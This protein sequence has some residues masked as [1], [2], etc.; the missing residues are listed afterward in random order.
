MKGLMN[1]LVCLFVLMFVSTVSAQMT[2]GYTN[3]TFD[4]RDGIRFGSSLEQ[5][6][7]IK[8]SKEKLQLLQG[9]K[10]IGL[11]AA[12]GSKN[13]ENVNFFISE[14]AG[15]ASLY[16]QSVTGLSTSWK[17][18][19]FGT[20]YTITGDKDLFVGLTLV[21]DN[22]AR[23]PLTFDR[24][25]D[26]EGLSWA[27]ENG[28]WIDTYGTGF[29]MPNLE[30]L[31]DGDGSFTDLMLKTFQVDTYSKAGSPQ[32]YSGEVFNFG[33]ETIR[34]FD[35][36]CQIGNGDPVVLPITGIELKGRASYQFNL[37]EYT[38]ESS[39]DLP[40]S[41]S[42]GNVNGGQQD[43]DMTDNVN[44]S[45]AY[46][47]P[48]A[49]E[50]RLLV[51]NFTGQACGNCP[52][53]HRTME[54]VLRGMEDEIITVSHHAG[55]SPDAF[56]MIEDWEY[57]WFYNEGGRIYAPAV[58]VNRMQ[59]LELGYPGPVF[60]VSESYLRNTI[61]K[62]MNIQPYVS[63]DITTDFN[64]ETRELKAKVAVYTHVVPSSKRYT[65]NVFLVQ[66]SII[67]YQSSG[68]GE[69]VHNHVC[70]GSLTTVWGHEITLEKGGRIIKDF[71]YTLPDAILSTYNG[72]EAVP[73]S[74]PTVLK[75]MHLVAFVSAY[76]DTS[77]N[78]CYVLNCNATTFGGKTS[79][80]A[81]D[82]TEMEEVFAEVYAEG[83]TVHI[84]GE[85]ERADIYDMA[86]KRV[87]TVRG[88]DAFDMNT[89][90]YIIRLAQKGKIVSRKLMIHD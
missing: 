36:T 60:N 26:S 25:A 64:D 43:A 61:N 76:S 87:K 58:M 29:G 23:A 79:G 3:G 71:E 86:G 9:H 85:Y 5:G 83:R 82:E 74:I 47:Y 17:N 22:V 32:I 77:A 12:L 37:P 2:I 78:D 57:C 59:N 69:Y 16:S 7:A 6:I 75:D 68:G 38:I 54:G 39:G 24:S 62:F 21:C 1:L 55:Y 46:I 56:T 49:T 13:V 27:Y 88:E 63:I 35:V 73:E 50:K 44:E 51:E 67:A 8:L 11:R 15:G 20:S 81:I 28:A 66:D 41:I 10:I 53:G 31:L 19:N 52:E 14:S 84:T 45:V 89:G 90:F 34:S 80:S 33:T 18:F 65:L 48:A 70:R 42:I 4:R 72:A 30:L 40:V